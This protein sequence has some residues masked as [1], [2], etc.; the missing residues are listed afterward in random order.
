M[1]RAKRVALRDER[2]A[3][4]LPVSQWWQG[5]RRQVLDGAM[6]EAIREMYRSST[7]FTEYRTHFRRFWQLPE[8]FE[9]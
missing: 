3:Q 7:S 1:T 8:S 2:R 5:G 9:I 6:P 4:S